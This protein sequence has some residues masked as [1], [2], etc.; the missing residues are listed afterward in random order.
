MMMM[1]II[2]GMKGPDIDIGSWAA[3][4]DVKELEDR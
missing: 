1:M 3:P 4:E 2:V